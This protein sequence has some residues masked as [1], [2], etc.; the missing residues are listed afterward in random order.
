MGGFRVPLLDD[1]APWQ[2]RFGERAA[3]TGLLAELR[4]SLAIEIGTAEGGSLRRLS[5]AAGEIHSFDLVEPQPDIQALENVT[6]HTGDSHAL[7]PEL[8]GKLAEAGRNVDFVLVDGDHTAE[9]VA[10]DMN[11]LI[12]SP[13][14]GRTVILAHDSMNEEV[15]S[16]LEAVDYD[17]WPAVRYVELDWVAGYVLSE[18]RFG[19]QLWGGLAAVVVDAGAT[20]APG[21]SVHAP[22]LTSIHEVVA[23]G[24]VA[25][26]DQAALRADLET[27]R[28]ALDDV[29]GSASWRVTAP[30]RAAKARVSRRA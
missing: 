20:R 29:M 16:G 14:L 24:R 8:L 12:G 22:G 10:R 2:M 11:D 1:A 3:L 23:A 25:A 7:L 9:G 13:A 18:P 19:S 27:C 30:L 28:T 6:L 4:P 21:S 17:A 15:R 26:T 5:A